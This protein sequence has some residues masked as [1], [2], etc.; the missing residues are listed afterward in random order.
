MA[1]STESKQPLPRL[2]YRVAEVAKMLGESRAT[3]HRRVKAGKL[4]R[5]ALGLISTDELRRL[6]LN[7]PDHST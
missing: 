7:P 6:G 4:R 3:T 5:N 2:G 1:K